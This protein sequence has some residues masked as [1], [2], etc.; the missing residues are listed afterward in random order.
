M[1]K[2]AGAKKDA[3]V[4]MRRN[5]LKEKLVKNPGV[6]FLG[7]DLRSE[8]GMNE[9]AFYYDVN[10]LRKEDPKI[11]MNA[12]KLYYD[13]PVKSVIHEVKNPERHT[14]M[15]NSE[16]HLDPTA[17]KAIEAVEPEAK[18]M[19]FP[20]VGDVWHVQC[21]SGA[22]TKLFIVLAIDME[23]RYATCIE[24]N[25]N[26]EPEDCDIYIVNKPIKYFMGNKRAWSVPLS[27]LQTVRERIRKYLAIDPEIVE[28][29]KIVEKEVVKEVPVEVEKVVE[30]ETPAEGYY[31]KSDV[32]ALLAIQKAEIYEQ[33]FKMLAKAR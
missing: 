14:K 6:I 16:G 27:Y 21:S 12:G 32:D 29:E 28:V 30:K 8:F 1:A 15:K 2:V 24:Y 26:V 33:C 3:A 31:S 20:K 11:I 13:A 10:I 19:I 18:G 17:A 4:T 25:G 7:K 5:S 9:G 23:S 22:S